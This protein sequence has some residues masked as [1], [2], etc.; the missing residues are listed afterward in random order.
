MTY[1]I[2]IGAQ[3]KEVEE[4]KE[5]VKYLKALSELGFINISVEN[6]K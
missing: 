4:L 1:T 3:E 6:K 5:V 2:K